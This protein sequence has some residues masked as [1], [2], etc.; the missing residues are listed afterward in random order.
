M[1]KSRLIARG[2]GVGVTAFALLVSA[3]NVQAAGAQASKAEDDPTAFNGEILLAAPPGGWSV[4]HEHRQKG[5]LVK[6]YEP[7]YRANARWQETLTFE[8]VLGGA[9][10]SV[11]EIEQAIYHKYSTR[12]ADVDAQPSEPVPGGDYESVIVSLLCF[13]PK[14]AERAKKKA[15]AKPAATAIDAAFVM[16]KVMRGEFNGYRIE[17]VWQGPLDAP[18]MPANS[19]RQQNSWMS[20]F[21][22]IAVC[23]TLTDNCDLRTKQSA[24]S[25]PRFRTMREA[26]VSV[27]PIIDIALVLE[28]AEKIGRLTGQAELCGE[29]VSSFLSKID[30]MFEFVTSSAD[31][32][33]TALETFRKALTGGRNTALGSAPSCGDTLREYRAHPTRPGRFPKFLNKLAAG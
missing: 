8:T 10:Q 19:K 13:S 16:V 22:T 29:D 4:R 24:D 30:R 18:A 26:A 7:P 25:N 21:A 3:P 15:P 11:D 17:R 31:D 5:L 1:T 6:A 27:K 20:Y 32:R 2:L 33:A 14:L 9:A 23:N 12:C 28:G